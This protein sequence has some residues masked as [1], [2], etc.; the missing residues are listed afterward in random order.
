MGETAFEVGERSLF[1]VS[2][3]GKTRGGDGR[4]SRMKKRENIAGCCGTK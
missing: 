4:D 1:A 2:A 3:R